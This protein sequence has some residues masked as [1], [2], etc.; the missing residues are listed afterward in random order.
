[1][2]R[3]YKSFGRICALG[4]GSTRAYIQQRAVRGGSHESTD[5][6]HA[7]HRFLEGGSATN[8]NKKREEIQK[9]HTD[10]REGPVA[11]AGLPYYP[12]AYLCMGRRLDMGERNMISCSDIC[13]AVSDELCDGC[14]SQEE[15]HGRDGGDFDHDLFHDCMFNFFAIIREANARVTGP[16][17]ETDAT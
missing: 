13:G 7:P 4:V 16:W 10:R 15:C 17:R 3:R 14:V 12:R 2:S 6:D 9:V 8:G 1:M 11:E 5:R